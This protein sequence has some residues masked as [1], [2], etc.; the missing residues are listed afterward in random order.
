[1]EL[2]IGIILISMPILFALGLLGFMMSG[3]K[4]EEE[5]KLNIVEEGETKRTAFEVEKT[6]AS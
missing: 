1:M 4:G 3:P 5:S 6:I 2:F